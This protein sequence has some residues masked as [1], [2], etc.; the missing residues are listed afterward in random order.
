MEMRTLAHTDLKVSRACYGTMTFGKQSDQA[1]STRLVDC[2][3]DHGINFFDTANMYS[4]GVA[5]TILGNALKGRRDKVVLASKVK[6]K[7][8][9]GAD[10]E[11][12]SRGAILKAIDLSLSRLQTDYLD[13]YYQIGR[14]SCRERV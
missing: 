4:A 8:G 12:L 6:F 9:D 5:E 14:A 2:C 7:M 10:E 3:L 1:L 13:L 11:G